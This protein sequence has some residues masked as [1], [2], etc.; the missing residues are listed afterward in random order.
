MGRPR[1]LPVVEADTQ[2]VV[3]KSESGADFELSAKITAGSLTSNAKELRARIEAELQNYSVEKYLNDPESAKKDK[4]FLNKVKD[5]ISDKRK[6]VSK[7]WN[8]PLDNFLEE[9]KGLEKSINEASSKLND[10]VKEADDKEKNEKKSKIEAYYSTLDFKIVTLDRIF[11]QKWLNKTV[12]MDQIMLEIESITE[13]ISGELATIKSM[14]TEDSEILQAFYLETLDLNATLQKG[15]QLRA[16]RKVIQEA[17]EQKKVEMVQNMAG[18]T[19]PAVKT[20]VIPEE[21]KIVQNAFN[22]NVGQPL[23][24]FTLKLYG[25]K[26][27]LIALRQYIDSHGIK[28]EKL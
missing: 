1:K 10:I 19:K 25:T 28:Y 12:K 15:N 20:V 9:M 6:E 4:A 16:N 21:N 11:N 8:S 27:Q 23:M 14:Q 24:N 3:A 2:M 17:E 18:A 26:E 5:S 7:A 13:K 22:E